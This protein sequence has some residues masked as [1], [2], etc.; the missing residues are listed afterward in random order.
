MLEF[1]GQIYHA[2]HIILCT[3]YRENTKEFAFY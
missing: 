3:E 1:I 2:K